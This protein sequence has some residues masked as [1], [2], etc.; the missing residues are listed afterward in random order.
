MIILKVD[1]DGTLSIQDSM[2]ENVNRYKAYEIIESDLESKDKIFSH[3]YEIT[4]LCQY[5]QNFS[6]D[7]GDNEM[8]DYTTD[9]VNEF[10]SVLSDKDFKLL[11][12]ALKEWFGRI[13]N[14]EEE[15]LPYNSDVINPINGYHAAYRMF[16]SNF[17]FDEPP[18]WAEDVG[19]EA[20]D[21]DSPSS[22]YY[23][24]VLEKDIDEDPFFF[25]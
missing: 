18:D 10:L 24:A 3:C 5:I 8:D 16:S 22:S 17:G 2:Y 19:I 12:A 4:A 20:Y 6:S 15:I 1:G 7:Y 14:G 23:A 21:G 13:P 9:D 11:S 25:T